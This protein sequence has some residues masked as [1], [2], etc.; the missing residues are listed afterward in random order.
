MRLG[1]GRGLGASRSCR[2]GKGQVMGDEN[3]LESVVRYQ[4]C[5][6]SGLKEYGTTVDTC[7]VPKIRTRSMLHPM[8]KRSYHF[9]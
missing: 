8:E 3:S 1:F 5:M 4:Y 2:I 9:S 6:D 7:S